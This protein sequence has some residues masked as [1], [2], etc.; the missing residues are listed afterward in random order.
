MCVNAEN[1][2]LSFF[3]LHHPFPII[4]WKEDDDVPTVPIHA[5]KAWRRL[6]RPSK[7]LLSDC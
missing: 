2:I 1:A 4:F 3:E 7:P 6:Q 5:G